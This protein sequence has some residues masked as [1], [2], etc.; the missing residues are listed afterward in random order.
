MHPEHPA[1]RLI[2]QSRVHDEWRPLL[3]QALETVDH[4][5]LQELIDDPDWLPGPDR[6]FAAFRRDRRNCRYLLFGESPYPRPESANGIAFQDAAVGDLWSGNGLSK[7]V[8]R[9][10][11]LRNLIKTALVAEG[12]LQTDDD[13]RITQQAIAR[14]DKSRLIGNLD[15]F[16]TALEA[17][18]VLAFNALPVL[19]TGRNKTREARHWHGFLERLLQ[20]LRRDGITLVLWGRIA[21]DILALPG[22]AHFRVLQSEHPYNVSFIHN[23]V[24][25]R[26]FAD[27]R[28]L[29]SPR[30]GTGE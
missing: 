22:A 14:L 10:T 16:F 27:W 18:G 5:Y 3:L 11:S 2:G 12:H 28:L 24:M 25:R 1:N 29:G 21:E 23:P 6:L 30:Q 7:A 19:R 8:N 15:A 9:A 20:G 13:G 4:G 17:R 26:L